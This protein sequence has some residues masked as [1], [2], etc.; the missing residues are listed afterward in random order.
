MKLALVF[1]QL[2]YIPV[3][4]STMFGSGVVIFAGLEVLSVSQS[5]S[6]IRVEK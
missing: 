3:S 2:P 6:A 5:D 1:V 4:V